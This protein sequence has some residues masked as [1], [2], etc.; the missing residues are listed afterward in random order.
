MVSLGDGSVPGKKSYSEMLD[1]KE[2]ESHRNFFQP[3]Y[4][5]LLVLVR[6]KMNN[7]PQRLLNQTAI[8]KW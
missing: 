2:A 8:N 4:L 6:F 1:K 7:Q 5:R 3:S